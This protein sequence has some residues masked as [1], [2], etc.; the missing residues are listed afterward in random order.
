MNRQLRRVATLALIL[1]GGLFI[2]LNVIQLLRADELVSN[3]ANRR[4]IIR[5]HA[6]QRGPIVVGER[7]IAHSVPTGGDLKYLRVYEEP[8]RYAHVTG[9]YSFVVGRS[10]L[11]RALNDELVDTPRELFA[12]SLAELLAGRDAAGN[13]VQLTLDP[14]VQAEAQRAL[15]DR[16]GAVAAVDPTTGAVLAHYSNPGYDPNVLASH[17]AEQIMSAWDRLQKAPGRP[18]LDRVTREHYPPGSTF[19]VVVAAAALER[20]LTPDTAFPDSAAYT[21]PQTTRAI[22]NFGGGPCTGDPTLSLARAFRVSCNTVFA[23]LGVQLGPQAL[24]ETAEGLGFNRQVPYVLPVVESQIPKALDAPATA[25]SAI[26]Q[27]DV[28][29]TALHGALIAAAVANDGTLVRPY[30]VTRVLDSTG[31]LVRGPDSGEWRD[32]RFPSRAVSPRTARVLRELM[33]SVV[34]A[35]TGRAAAIPD[36]EVGGKTGTAQNPEGTPTVW[37][38]G[39]AGDRV[40]V[41]VVLPD[42]GEGATGGGEAAPIARAVMEAALGRR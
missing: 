41:A 28:R 1:F 26:G 21:P 11:E 31:R 19:K 24:I 8:E 40:A 23:R 6:F 10:G 33:V 39:F 35:G 22:N 14:R 4:L 29:L 15:G 42:A 3:P 16:V 36:I 7:E 32:R 18:L 17:D 20:G 30:L 37:F 25:Q 38:V 27:R 9:H 2:N 12:Q 34:T 5:E 13:T